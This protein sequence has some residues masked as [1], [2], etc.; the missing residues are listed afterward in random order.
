MPDERDRTVGGVVLA[1][2]TSARY[3]AEN[4]LLAPISGVPMVRV[5]AETAVESTLEEVVAVV[6]HQ[7]EAL[8]DA[9]SATVDA[10]RY[11]GRYPD[12][13]SESVRHGVA[14]ARQHDWDAIVFVLGD[15]PFVETATLDLLE[16]TYQSSTASIV[17]PRYDGRRGNPVLFGR[18]HFEQLASLSG[19]RGGREILLNHEGTRFVDVD[20][21]GVVEDIDTRQDR[22]A[23]IE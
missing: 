15:M 5:V 7:N 18:Q 23:H 21:S 8:S 11:N 20:D 13:Q 12:G 2:G 22:A 10:V 17:V 4:K 3:G 9:L 16:G 6:G 1:A 14:I 19:D